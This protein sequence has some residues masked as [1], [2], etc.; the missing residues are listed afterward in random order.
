[1]HQ[2]QPNHAL[3]RDDRIETHGLKL[4]LDPNPVA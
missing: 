2:V 3:T 4:S 1:M